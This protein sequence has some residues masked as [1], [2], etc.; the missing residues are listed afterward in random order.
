M[1][2]ARSGFSLLEIV[3][4][5]VLLQVCLTGVVG[6]FT[7]ASARLAR[8]VLVERAAAELAAVADSLSLAGA[9]GGG[10]ALRGRWRVTWSV[11]GSVAV[12]SA[13]LADDPERTPLVEVRLP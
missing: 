6:L 9:A 7:L 12:L 13:S 1:T 10:E 2:R 11:A 3:V 4:A 8:A 5:L